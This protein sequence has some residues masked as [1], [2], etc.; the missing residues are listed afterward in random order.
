VGSIHGFITDRLLDGALDA[1]KLLRL[2]DGDIE[3]VRLSRRSWRCRD[4]ARV[5]RTE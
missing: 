1:L 5:D 4:G 3:T 2:P